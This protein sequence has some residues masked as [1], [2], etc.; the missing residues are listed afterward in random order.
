MQFHSS[1]FLFTDRS[2]LWKQIKYFWNNHIRLLEYYKTERLWGRW[3][4]NLLPDYEML[5]LGAGDL[6][7]HRVNKPAVTTSAT[8]KGFFLS[9]C[10]E[11]AKTNVSKITQNISFFLLTFSEDLV[12]T[13]FYISISLDG[14]ICTDNTMI[15]VI[16]CSVVPFLNE[17]VVF[18][19]L[20]WILGGVNGAFLQQQ[21][22]T[23]TNIGSVKYLP[24]SL[25]ASQFSPGLKVAICNVVWFWKGK[26]GY[27]KVV[28]LEEFWYV[29][30]VNL[31]YSPWCSVSFL[32][33]LCHFTHNFSHIHSFTH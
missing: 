29:C 14:F 12:G 32:L 15:E 22:L 26:K 4:K 18:W 33:F 8:F 21:L 20:I 1:L 23:R 11:N 7:L 28:F 10:S 31:F 24:A 13:K 27:I 5:G 19:R 2:I 9:M 25:S 6:L 16:T 3:G 17:E 30:I